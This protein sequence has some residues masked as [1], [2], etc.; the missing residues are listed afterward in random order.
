MKSQ[1]TRFWGP[2]NKH[3]TAYQTG[4]TGDDTTITKC[5]HSQM[6]TF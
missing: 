1:I 3:A 5:M 6:C 2:A 4:E